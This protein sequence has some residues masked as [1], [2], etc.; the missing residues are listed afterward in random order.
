MTRRARRVR[1][2]ILVLVGIVV[3]VPI[4]M[5]LVAAAWVSMLDRPDH[6][7]RVDGEEREYL[8]HVPKGYDATRPTPLVISLHAGALWPAHEMNLT[9]WNRLA[10]EQN[11]IVVYPAGV[12]QLLRIVRVWRTEPADVAK[13][14]RFI[15]ALIDALTAE[16]N[17]D[18]MRIYADG[19]SNGGGMVF[20]LSCRL[21]T[22][23]AAVGMVAAAE[24]LPPDWCGATPMPLIAFHGDADP[25]VPYGGGPLGDPFNPIKPV[26]PPVRDWVAAWA[27]RNGCTGGADDRPIAADVTRLEYRDCGDENV[28]LYTLLGGG[29]TWPGG[30]PMM[31]WRVG[32]TNTSIDATA[33]MWAFYRAHPGRAL[34]APVN[35]AVETE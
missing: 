24:Q 20:A 19:M 5:V 3:G 16:Y 33:T 8:L 30:E 25:L 35:A 26:Y 17:I 9:R 29:H 23:L 31:R 28:V 6:T 14:V 4:A 11:L 7:L 10:D 18:S 34:V 2:I 27:K 12:P 1:T 22:R 21:S 15:D 32:P 13:D